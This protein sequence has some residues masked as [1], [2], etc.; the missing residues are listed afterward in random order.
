MQKQQKVTIRSARRVS[1]TP[2]ERVQ[3]SP[4]FFEPEPVYDTNPQAL[5]PPASPPPSPASAPAADEELAPRRLAPRKTFSAA[6]LEGIRPNVQVY[7]D[8]TS[9]LPLDKQIKRR[10]N[11]ERMSWGRTEY[12]FWT[13]FSLVGY[14]TS[15][16]AI[17]FFL[18]LL[19]IPF[20]AMR[21][22]DL[23]RKWYWSLLILLP[24]AS[25]VVK[26]YCLAWPPP[27]LQSQPSMKWKIPVLVVAW[28]LVFAFVL[29]VTDARARSMSYRPY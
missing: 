22:H 6:E 21:L 10:R 27:E 26:I 19:G 29:L 2:Q 14:F 28:V 17:A 9:N 11:K 8:T 1:M 23:G 16:P 3:E 20:A 12:S 25:I 24:L 7:G 18:M 4:Q 13:I 5:H 15:S